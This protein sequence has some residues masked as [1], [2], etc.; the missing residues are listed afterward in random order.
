MAAKCG[1]Y[2]SAAA[3]RG[4]RATP[5]PIS[6][7]GTVT[8]EEYDAVSE[9]PYDLEVE[10]AELKSVGGDDVTTV[11]TL[12]AASAATK[13]TTGLL[14]EMCAVHAAQMRE[15]TALVAAATVIN[16]PAPPCKEGQAQAQIQMNPEG[17]RCV[18]YPPPEE[19]R[20]R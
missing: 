17:T 9:Y 12:E 13:T 15:I 19:L 16:A 10:N 4:T 2:K 11:S 18:Q 6:A 5:A 20:Q 14:A 7:P 8:R 3:L 1:G